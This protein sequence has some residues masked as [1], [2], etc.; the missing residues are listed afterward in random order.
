MYQFNIKQQ[1]DGGYKFELD[2]IKMII[3]DYQLKEGNHILTHPTKAIAYFI[4]QDNI[5]GISN[6][7]LNCDTA[8]AFYDAIIKQY[9]LFTNTGKT[10][11]GEGNGINTA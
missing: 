1:E 3:D 6:D 8:E 7:P 4:I 10:R 11:P 9:E 2:G 5:Y